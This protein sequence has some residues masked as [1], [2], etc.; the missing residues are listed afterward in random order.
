MR[1]S[2]GFAGF[3]VGAVNR[4]DA[5]LFSEKMSV[6]VGKERWS[7]WGTEQVT[8][9][10]L[11]ANAPDAVVLPSPAYECFLSNADWHNSTF[12]HFIGSHRYKEGVYKEKSLEAI[13][14]L[15]G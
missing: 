5:N 13:E 12:L 4:A 7:D 9:N 2:A 10:F 6:L 14:R 8:S 15:K 1:G 3:A 11:V